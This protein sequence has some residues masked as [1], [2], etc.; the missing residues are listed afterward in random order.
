MA[1]IKVSELA[2]AAELTGNELVMAVQGGVS[3]KV[4]AVKFMPLTAVVNLTGSQINKGQVVYVT[5]SQGTRMTVALALANA[6]S[7]SATILGVALTNIDNGAEGFI[8]TSGLEVTGVSTSGYAD[9]DILW[10]SPT[11]PGGLT[12]T[13]PTA[14]NHLVMV[15]YVV[16]GGTSGGGIIHIHTQNGYEL[17]ELHDVRITS[18]AAKQI[19]KRNEANTYWENSSV[20]P[21]PNTTPPATP[22]GGGILYVEG[23]ALKFKGS[24]GTVTVVAPA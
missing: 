14:P 2:T 4:P 21:L 19:I 23:G 12:K 6:D 15:G 18:V 3:V 24:S 9:G 13:K 20:L 5:G 22:T 1:T 7:T 8:A 17:D 10:L 11:V 16:K